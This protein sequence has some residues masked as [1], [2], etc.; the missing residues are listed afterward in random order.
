[1]SRARNP[2]EAGVV[3]VTQVAAGQAFNVIP[4]TAEV[5]IDIRTLPGDDGE[6]VHQMLRD[7]AERTG[8]VVGAGAAMCRAHGVDVYGV[9]GSSEGVGLYSRDLRHGSVAPRERGA[10]LAGGEPTPLPLAAAKALTKPRSVKPE[11]SSFTSRF[12]MPRPVAAGAR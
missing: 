4:D 7:A 6:G 2:A 8:D 5:Q 11:R 1:M 10:R 9:A 12:P 3:S